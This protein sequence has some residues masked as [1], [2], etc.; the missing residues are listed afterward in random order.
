MN[1]S[2]IVLKAMLEAGLEKIKVIEEVGSAPSSEQ[3]EVVAEETKPKKAEAT[4]TTKKSTAKK[5]EAEPAPESAPIEEAKVEAAKAEPK[6]EVTLEQIRA[7]LQEKRAAGK[8]D[9]FKALFESFGVQRLPDVK[10][11]DYGKLLTAAEAL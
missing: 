11:E 4:S 8:K 5:K 6:T 9:K 7:V 10:E 3:P 2:I 1:S